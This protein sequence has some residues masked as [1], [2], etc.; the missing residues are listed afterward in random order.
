MGAVATVAKKFVD[1]CGNCIERVVSWW[2]PH[3]ER[4]NNIT[5]NYLIGN[6]LFIMNSSDPRNVGEIMGI[7]REKDELEY[8]SAQTYNQLSYGDRGRI[9]E[10]L[11]QRDY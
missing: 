1:W 3:K 5:Y 2:S 7:K 9:D 6:Q 11:D 10:L 8:I 4:T